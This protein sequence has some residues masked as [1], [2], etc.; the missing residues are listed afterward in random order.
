[1]SSSSSFQGQGSHSTDKEDC[2]SGLCALSFAIRLRVL[3]SPPE[4]QEEA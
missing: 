4:A 2:L 1:M 3:D